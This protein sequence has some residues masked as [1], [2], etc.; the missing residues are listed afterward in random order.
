MSEDSRRLVA[1]ARRVVADCER[2]MDAA[3][4]VVRALPEDRQRVEN[5]LDATQERH[6]RTPAP[7]S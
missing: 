4:E 6:S 2:Y 3:I 5:R 7:E 1:E